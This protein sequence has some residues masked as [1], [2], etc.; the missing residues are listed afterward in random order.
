MKSF[1]QLLLEK[2]AGSGPYGS[3]PAGKHLKPRLNLIAE[4]RD[5]NQNHHGNGRDQKS[6]LHDVLPGFIGQ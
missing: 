3:N 5:A 1:E 4:R 6:V 2:C